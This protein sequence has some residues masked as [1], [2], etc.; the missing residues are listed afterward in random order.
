M[1]R[2]ALVCTECHEV[3]WVDREGVVLEALKGSRRWHLCE[4]CE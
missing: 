2:V 3:T 4:L 1:S